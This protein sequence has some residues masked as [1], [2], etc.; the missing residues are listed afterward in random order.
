LLV[1]PG[2]L[3]PIAEGPCLRAVDERRRFFARV[4]GC[5]RFHSWTTITSACG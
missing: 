2:V 5:A 1:Q 3:R 4:C